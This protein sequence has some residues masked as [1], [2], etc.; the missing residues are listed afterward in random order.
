MNLFWE[1]ISSEEQDA[2]HVHVD[3]CY[4]HCRAIIHNGPK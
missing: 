4:A 2:L 3:P 1:Q